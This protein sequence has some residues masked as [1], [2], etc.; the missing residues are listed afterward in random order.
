MMKV[1]NSLVILQALSYLGLDVTD[2]KGRQLRES[3]TSDPQGTVSYGGI[4][5][6]FTP[7][8]CT[9][10]TWSSAS[11]LDE[12]NNHY[13]YNHFSVDLHSLLRKS[14]I[15][16]LEVSLKQGPFWSDVLFLIIFTSFS[17]YQHAHTYIM[18]L[19]HPCNKS[20]SCA[21]ILEW[22]GFY[23]IFNLSNVNY[24]NQFRGCHFTI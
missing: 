8:C 24:F 20:R 2:E 11:Q 14:H 4:N 10:I 7:L 19:H 3:L 9:C 15:S 23:S 1:F 18:Y 13:F 21:N 17:N 6:S 16:V 5:A 12:G 22:V